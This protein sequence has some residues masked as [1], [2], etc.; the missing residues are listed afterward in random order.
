MIKDAKVD[1]VG[2][3]GDCEDKMVK[4]SPLTS[5]SSN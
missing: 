1:N 5:K 3:G 2:V 4:R